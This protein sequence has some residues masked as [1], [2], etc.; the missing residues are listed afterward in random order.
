MLGL[1]TNLKQSV[2]QQADRIID[3]NSTTLKDQPL[4]YRPHSSPCLCRISFQHSRN[5]KQ[6]SA[7]CLPIRQVKLAARGDS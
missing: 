5:S 2:Q 4:E 7:V 1:C 3:Y 6:H